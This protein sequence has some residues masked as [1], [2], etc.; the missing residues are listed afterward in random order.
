M[1]ATLDF[2]GAGQTA[3]VDPVLEDIYFT[4]D[5]PG[6]GIC[7]FDTVAENQQFL[8]PNRY[9]YNGI[10]TSDGNENPTLNKV[11]VGNGNSNDI[12]VDFWFGAYWNRELTLGEKRAFQENP[13]QIFKPREIMVPI[14]EDLPELGTFEKPFDPRAF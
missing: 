6:I 2:I 12:D 7:S 13:W 9:V 10:D 4:P 3:D 8:H 11:V 14:N 1:T 5:T